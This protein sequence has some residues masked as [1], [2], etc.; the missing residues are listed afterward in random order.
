MEAREG[1]TDRTIRDL[2]AK[3]E[4]LA[5]LN[6]LAETAATARDLPTFFQLGG[7]QVMRDLPCDFFA[8][9]LLDEERGELVLA[10]QIG[11]PADALRVLKRVP[12]G[13]PG[14]GQVAKDGTARVMQMDEYPLAIRQV[15]EQ[16]GYVSQA[17]VPLMVRSRLVGV[18]SAA[19]RERRDEATAGLARLQAMGAPFAAAVEAQRLLADARRQVAD[20]Q[21]VNDLTLS[22]FGTSPGDT[23]ALLA[24][25]C[26]EIGRALGARAVIVFLTDEREALLRGAASW[27]APLPPGEIKLPLSGLSLGADCLRTQ[28]PVQCEDSLVDPCC[29]MSGVAGAPALSLLLVPLTSRRAARGVVAIA[30]E[31]GRR[32]RDAEVA[33]AQALASAAAM[34]LENAE[35]H[36]ATRRHAEELAH[37]Q[38]QLVQQE[39][40]AALGE[41]SAVVA[42]EVRNPLGAIFNSLGSLRRLLR[43]EGDARM[44]LDIVGEEADRLNRIVGDLLD[45]ARPSTPTLRPEPVDRLLD[46][47]VGAALGDNPQ[48]IVLQ[49]SVEPA[50]PLVPMDARLMRQAVLNVAVNAVQAMQHGG[51]LSIG[52]RRDRGAVRI[53]IAD[54]GAG[55]PNEVRHRI[56]EPFF[57]TKASGTGL[58]LAVVKRI[59]EGH[60]G[61]I[62]VES[63][64][65][66][67][68][69][70]TIRLPLAEPAALPPPAG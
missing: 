21:A 50:L 67:G 41:M 22:V 62:M 54:T 3:N 29:K 47:A 13:G 7:E 26:Q 63:R 42:H 25:A 28:A 48:G 34:A 64:S 5:A 16:C 69:A 10:H 12:V 33:L 18:M 68:T 6:R 61:Q 17:S 8:A 39:R 49:R 44:L 19:F 46:D 70:F 9:W 51:K 31:R 43:P 60:Q 35:L 38:A 15:A 53:E 27:G 55:I 11:A 1:S 4:E 40:L 23:H 24:A 52:A 59:V 30:G 57:T 2:Q 32:F 58:G 66:Q 37:A 20:L 65:G 14:P 45:F 56:F 36:A